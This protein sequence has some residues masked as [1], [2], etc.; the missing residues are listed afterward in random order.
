[1]K[2][3][4]QLAVVASLVPKS[5]PISSARVGWIVG[6]SPPGRA[7]VDYPGSTEGPFEAVST[8]AASRA[9]LEAA[10]AR[11]QSVVLLFD[12][13]DPRSPIIVGFVVPQ[14]PVEEPKARA[15]GTRPS[16]SRLTTPEVAEVDGKRVCIEG[17][18]EVILRCGEASI[19]LRRNGKVII[20]GAYVESHSR[21]TNRIKGGTVEVN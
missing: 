13:G 1:L 21:G 5:E 14:M 12:G 17:M 19:T 3:G 20:R 11:R 6:A 16:A 7:L 18:D 4:R 15:K 10:A 9:E 8:V 2:A